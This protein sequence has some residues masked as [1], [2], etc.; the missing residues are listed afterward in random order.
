[1]WDPDRVRRR[2][3]T[4]A[5]TYEDE[6][7]VLRYYYSDPQRLSYIESNVLEDQ[8]VEWILERAD[9]SE[10]SLSFDQ[11]LNPGQSGETV[12]FMMSCAPEGFRSLTVQGPHGAGLDAP[13]KTELSDKE[14]P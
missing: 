5:S 3:E 7:E 10:E 1:M 11:V 4:I 9:I 8:V 6:A 12:V 13:R 14:G 2:I